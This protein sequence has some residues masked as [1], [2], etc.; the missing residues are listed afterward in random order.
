MDLLGIREQFIKQSGRVDLVVDQTSYADN[1]AD[2]FI[3]SG[4][5]TL[6]SLLPTQKSSALAVVTVSSGDFIITTDARSIHGMF[7]I[8]PATTEHYGELLQLKKDVYRERFG[9]KNNLVEDTGRPLYFT[10][11]NIRDESEEV[12]STFSQVIVVGPTPDQDYDVIID[13]LYYPAE[14]NA[15]TD[16]NF[17]SINHPDT[18]VQGA[19]YA[20]ERFYRNTQGMNDHMAAIMRDVQ[21]IDYDVAEQE[22]AITDQMADSFN[23]RL[24]TPRRYY[25]DFSGNR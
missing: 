21:G 6:D 18:L 5:K 19:L 16:D 4:Q 20:L 14:L 10:I 2:F 12:N 17:W 11:E 8:N 24:L 22:A 9:Y 3:R 13:G 23:E 7:L 25:G 1:G 15:D